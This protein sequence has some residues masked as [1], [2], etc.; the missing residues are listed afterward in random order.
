MAFRTIVILLLALQTYSQP[1]FAVRVNK[2]WGLID[3]TGKIV[4][5]PAYESLYVYGDKNDF[6]VA[7]TTDSTFL[8]NP[9]LQIVAHTNYSSIIGHGEGIFETQLRSA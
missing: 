4:L 1:Y 3:S 9:R 7:H 5:G 8:F 2:L 6:A